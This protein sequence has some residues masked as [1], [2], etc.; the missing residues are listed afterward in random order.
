MNMEQKDQKVV[1]Y[2][3]G[4]IYDEERG[5][6]PLCG[7]TARSTDVQQPARRERLTE[8][9]RK[10]RRNAAKGKYAAPKKKKSE[11][12]APKGILIAAV[13]FLALAVLVVLYFI[14]DMI[15]WWPGF[16]NIVERDAPS[17]SVVSGE[18]E[19]LLLSSE[20]LRFAA[21]GE[22]KELTV[23]VNLSCDEKVYCHS[24][25]SQVAEVAETA[26]TAMGKELKSVTFTVK[27]VSEGQTQIV[28]QCGDKLASCEIVCGAETSS[29]PENSDVST[30]GDAFVP[31][32]NYDSDVT[33]NEKGESATLRVTNLPDGAEV[34]WRSAD[35][36]IA[37]ID[38]DGK[39]TAVGSGTTTVTVEVEGKTA[40]VKV[41]CIF[42]GSNGSGAH[43]Q[44]GREDVS[45]SVG[46]KFD[47]YLYD[48]DGNHIDD[49]TY[50]VGDASIC[51]VK[52]SY[53]TALAR[54][55]TK[56]T[57]TYKG[58]EFVCIVRV[59]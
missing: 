46:E 5:K 32:L 38:A 51:E 44:A 11:Q 45:V 48:S 13:V 10:A 30:S 27:A 41:N 36:S 47:L 16:E 35:E 15:G 4:T 39:V 21:A 57:V 49:V 20:T 7:S 3:C 12:E 6:C 2:Y 28:V 14:G 9:E 17:V 8:E 52:D 19:E 55:T 37:S 40:E 43:L 59:G 54:G 31:K 50:T 58:E 1:C 23:S 24:E 26:T 34:L 18:C 42:S 53:V 22:T 25:D 56:V 29:Q 33:L